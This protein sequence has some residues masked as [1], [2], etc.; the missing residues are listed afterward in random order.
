MYIA[1]NG[2][3]KTEAAHENAQRRTDNFLCH[4]RVNIR[5][6]TQN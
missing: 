5:L 6:N 2:G 1:G 4:G 3:I